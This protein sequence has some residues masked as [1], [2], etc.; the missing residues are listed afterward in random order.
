MHSQLF[1]FANGRW[2]LHHWNSTNGRIWYFA[3]D[4]QIRQPRYCY[5]I[6]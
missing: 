5:E 3:F 6:S 4:T 2:G 1:A